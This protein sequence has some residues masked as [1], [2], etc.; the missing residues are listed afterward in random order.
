MRKVG[1]VVAAAIATI[2]VGCGS[3]T[4]SASTPAGSSTGTAPSAATGGTTEPTGHLTVVVNSL[5][6]LGQDYM[7]VATRPYKPFTDEIFDY[8]VDQDATGKL[9]PGLA[10]SWTA[11]PAGPLP[12]RLPSRRRR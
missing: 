5:T 7:V 3:A 4:P 10:E 8:P 2:V 1:A 6:N 11:S 9:S 12:S